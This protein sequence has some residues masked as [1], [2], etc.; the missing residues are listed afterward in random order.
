ML[1]FIFLI[2]FLILGLDF[3]FVIML[4]VLH[5]HLVVCNDNFQ[6][7]LL[8]WSSIQNKS[9]SLDK[10]KHFQHWAL[11]FYLTLMAAACAFS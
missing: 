7:I 8:S 4:T 5:A 9:K 11:V 2:G 10:D 3:S 6:N 1:I